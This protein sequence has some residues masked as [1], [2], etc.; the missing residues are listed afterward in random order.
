MKSPS[1]NRAFS[2][3]RRARYVFLPA[4]AVVLL[5]LPNVRAADWPQFLGPQRNGLSSET[6]LVDAWPAG[7]LKVVWRVPGGVGMSGLAIQGDRLVTLVQ[8]DE[9]QWLV[10]HSAAT[11]KPA[12]QTELAPAYENSMGNGP[13]G[14][15][16]IVGERVYAFT[17]EGIL[18]AAELK[19]GKIAWSR[20]AVQ[21]LKGKEAD[22]GMASSPLVVGNQ[23][24]VAVGTPGASVAAFDTETGKLLWKAGDDPAGYSSP[25][26]LKVAGKEQIVAYTGASALGLAPTSGKTLWRYPYETNFACN[27]ANPIA[28]DGQVLLSSG[29]NHGSVLLKLNPRG[30][31][32][33]P[34]EV[35]TSQGPR[36]TLRSEWQTPILLGGHLYGMDNVGGAGPVTHLT[37]VDAKTGERK[38]QQTRYGKG[39]LI[40]A[41]GKLFLTMMSGELVVARPSPD[42]Y[43]ELGRMP[44][45]EM[46]R[47]A[48]ALANGLLYVRD[49]RE[50]VCVDVRK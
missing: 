36:S 48:P 28:I 39:N 7:G 20:H 24:L 19:T 29:E 2:K 32:F 33:E 6:G 30:D 5:A 45:V 10:A 21:E 26:L 37:C 23:V 42:K 27:I 15:P 50:I 43:V 49:D 35:W 13:R 17:G 38:W 4:I 31:A 34:E 11:G 47:Q 14:T 41:D 8:R 1:P 44:L 9:K 40:Y 12:W 22:Y 46:T 18:V 3:T 25:T 16:S